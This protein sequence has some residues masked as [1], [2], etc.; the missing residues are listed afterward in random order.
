[1]IQYT[2]RA[3]CCSHKILMTTVLLNEINF[4]DNAVIF[5]KTFIRLTFVTDV[6]LRWQWCVTERAVVLLRGQ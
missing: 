6:L 4:T 1:M 2:N 5:Y 3:K